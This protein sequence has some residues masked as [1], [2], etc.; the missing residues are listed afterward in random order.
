M[1]KQLKVR[2]E[3][4]ARYDREDREEKIVEL[5]WKQLS[6]NPY[7]PRIEFD[8]ETIKELAES[9]KEYG[10][11]EPIIVCKRDDDKE[12]YF[13][14]AGER[15][16]RACRK[17]ALPVKCVIRP[18]M[19]A[20]M[21]Q[22]TAFQENV[23]RDDLHPIEVCLAMERL[24]KTKAVKDWNEFEVMAGFNERS[25]GR[26]KCLAGLHTPAMRLAVTENYRNLNVL[27]ALSR[28]I[29]S[30]QDRVLQKIIDDHLGEELALRH[31]KEVAGAE[32]EPKTD[33][34][35]SVK[36]SS[37]GVA[38]FTL[39]SKSIIFRNTPHKLEQFQERLRLFYED[40]INE[41]ATT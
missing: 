9:I 8:E 28:H 22:I 10:Q 13:I 2:T 25:V 7:Q 27:E 6:P 15:R 17:E 21:L 26:Y 20:R 30:N 24:V 39:K 11:L 41:F 1:T 5:D 29:K 12:G 19:D 31:I 34:P 18:A 36:V 35:I 38:T 33:E 4:L 32:K 14:V 40:L 23:M 37:S 16:W 3:L